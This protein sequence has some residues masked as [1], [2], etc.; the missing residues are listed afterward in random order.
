MIALPPQEAKKY[1]ETLALRLG[2]SDPDK[3]PF[4][5]VIIEK[6]NDD[7]IHY[8]ANQD[9]NSFKNNRELI[10]H[11]LIQDQ[12][13]KKALPF[14][15][16]FLYLSYYLNQNSNATQE[17]IIKT[18]LEKTNTSL[19]NEFIEY[20]NYSPLKHK[21]NLNPNNVIQ[22][23]S[24]SNPSKEVITKEIESQPKRYRNRNMVYCQQCDGEMKK[25]ILSKGNFTGILGALLVFFL[26]LFILIFFAW[27]A[28]GIIIGL[29]MI[30]MSLGMGGKRIK[31]WKCQRCGYYFE[32]T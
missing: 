4:V 7:A 2:L 23:Y 32:R 25:T 19:E 11:Q 17:K 12:E 8:F 3:I 14:L 5:D 10:I 20:I 27:T 16:E 9:W 21:I 22:I 31:I 15:F 28:I 26:G 6:M 1:R 13:Y 29:L 30:I 18:V 24:Q